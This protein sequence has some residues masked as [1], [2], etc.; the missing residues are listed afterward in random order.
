MKVVKEFADIWEKVQQGA[1]LSREDGYR[2][3]RSTNLPEL[4]YMADF[5]R[6]KKHGNKAYFTHSINVNYTNLCVLTCKFCAFSRTKKDPDHYTW[7]VDEITTK[8]RNAAKKGVWEVHIVGGLHPDKRMDYYEDMCRSIKAACPGVLI[9]GFTAVEL[10]LFARQNKIDVREV[11]TRLKAAG[12][13]GV[14]GGG[15]EIFAEKVRKEICGTKITGKRWLE[16]HEVA[17]EVGFRTNATMLYGHIESP[18]D[19]VDRMMDL[20]DLQDKTGGFLAFVPLAYLPENNELQCPRTTGITDLQVLTVSRLLL[21]NFDHI[22]QLWNY[23]DEKLIQAAL[24]FGVDD[25]GGTNYDETIAREAG[26]HESGFTHGE[27]MDLIRRTG[28][29]PIESNSIYSELR[30]DEL[31]AA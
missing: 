22:R 8:V 20:R 5:V 18:E 3:I 27:L 12:L 15:A 9:Q 26:C 11:L 14:P 28:H 25:L 29:E 16:V 19:R 4:G 31:V 24:F 2:L 13:G 1:P 6:R 30:K 23:V 17:H 7:T 21:H 10:D